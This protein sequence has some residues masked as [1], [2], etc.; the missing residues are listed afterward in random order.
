[1]KGITDVDYKHAKIVCKG[2]EIKNLGDYHGLHVQSNTLLS[3]N[4]FKNFRKM[5]LEVYE[6]DPVHFLSESGLAR[7]AALKKDQ[8]KIRSFKW[9]WYVINGRIRY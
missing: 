6:L 9:Y 7:Q 2:F 1:M 3:A 4:V 5:W 8:N